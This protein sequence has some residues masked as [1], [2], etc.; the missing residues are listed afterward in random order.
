MTCGLDV[1]VTPQQVTLLSL[2]LVPS[3]WQMR[4]SIFTL[5]ASDSHHM[6]YQNAIE[7]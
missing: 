1:I 7:M 5:P 4:M 3:I 2:T 6:K